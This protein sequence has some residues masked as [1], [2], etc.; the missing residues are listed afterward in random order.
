MLEA[1]SQE[2]LDELLAQVPPRPG[3]GLLSH[4]RSPPAGSLWLRGLDGLHADLDGSATLASAAAL[5]PVLAG[6]VEERD[7][8]TNEHRYLAVASTT[9]GR[10]IG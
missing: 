3:L 6:N 7:L 10:Q 8:A 1:Y 5:N 9:H 2:A 4:E